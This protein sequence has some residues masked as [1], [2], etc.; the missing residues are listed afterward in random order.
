[1]KAVHWPS[2]IIVGLCLSAVAGGCSVKKQ[3]RYTSGPPNVAVSTQGLHQIPESEATEY[4]S[5]NGTSYVQ[6]NNST[7]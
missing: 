1:M 4:T 7:R 6:I 2:L 5:A 3:V